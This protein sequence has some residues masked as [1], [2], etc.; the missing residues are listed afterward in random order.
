[1]KQLIRKILL[2][3][4]VFLLAAAIPSVLREYIQT[5]HVYFLSDQFAEDVVT[6]FHGSGRFRFL[7]QPAVALIL[8]ILGGKR[9]AARATGIR[10]RR[11]V[12]QP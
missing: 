12:V 2:L 6:R 8:G 4:I 7:I 10:S 11:L 3:V 5:G 9:D 1:M